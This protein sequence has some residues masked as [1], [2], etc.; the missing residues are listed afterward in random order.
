MELEEKREAN[1]LKRSFE[2][3]ASAPPEAE[4]M[5]TDPTLIPRECVLLLLLLLHSWEFLSYVSVCVFWVFLIL[6]LC[7]FACIISYQLKVY[8]VAMKKNTIA[9]L[10]TGAGKTMIAIMMIKEIGKSLKEK[11]G[12]KKLIAFLAPTVHLVHQVCL[13]LCFWFI[14]FEFLIKVSLL[15]ILSS[16]V[17]ILLYG[18]FSVIF[19][20]IAAIG[21]PVMWS[22][23]EFCEIY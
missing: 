2:A 9:M 3:F 1:P 23:L 12:D 17:A 4:P 22:L 18:V 5:D 7:F 10:E 8:E 15:F 13:V 19:L 20:L 11:D 16:F 14:S 6:E 21:D